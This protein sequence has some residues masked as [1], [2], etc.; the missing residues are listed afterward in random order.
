[1]VQSE[2]ERRKFYT[3]NKYLQERQRRLHDS[4]SGPSFVQT[5]I[6]IYIYKTV[7][8]KTE[9]LKLLKNGNFDSIV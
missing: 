7:P 6:N 5:K 9:K 1:M 4:T 3:E 8:Q 2:R